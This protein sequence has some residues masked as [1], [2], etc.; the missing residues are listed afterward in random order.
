MKTLFKYYWDSITFFIIA[1]GLGAYLGGAEGAALSAMWSIF[2]LTAL[3]SAVSADNAVVNAKILTNWNMKWRRIFIWVGMPV[4]VFAVRGIV[5]LEIVSVVGDMSIPEAW[6]LALNDREGFKV[7][8]ESSHD[9]IMGFGGAFLLMVFLCFMTDKA[10]EDNWLGAESM[11][12][13]GN[14]YVWTIAV[15]AAVLSVAHFMMPKADFESFA[16]SVFIGTALYYGIK[17][18]KLATGSG[19][20]YVEQGIV[21]FLYLEVLDA[22][23]SLDGVVA[24]FAVTNNL[25]VLMLGLGAG[26]FLV[27]SM[28][29]HLLDTGAL[30]TFRF[31]DNGAFWS[32]GVLTACMFLSVYV[33]LP[34]WFIGGVSLISLGWAVWD[35]VKAN[36]ADDALP[37]VAPVAG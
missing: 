20:S 29:L 16:L 3:E 27:R 10:K 1:M 36:K 6:N 9:V 12:R 34:E 15:L 32:I 5:P 21:G 18:L 23:F 2:I 26:A 13:Y 17:L 11:F 25:I 30:K 7:I 14:F 33:H 35:S 8:I 19:K 22:S 31:L 28:T 4:A 37:P 24:G